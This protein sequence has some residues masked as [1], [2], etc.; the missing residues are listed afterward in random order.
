MATATWSDKERKTSRNILR[1]LVGGCRCR[2]GRSGHGWRDV[3][4]DRLS[5]ICSTLV[6]DVNEL[7]YDE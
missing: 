3:E 1:L 2:G 7:V 6:A 5:H 4:M